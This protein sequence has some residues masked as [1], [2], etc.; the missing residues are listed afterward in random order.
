MS[1]IVKNVPEIKKGVLRSHVVE[2]PS[3]IRDCSGIKDIWKE[4][5][6]NIIYVQMLQL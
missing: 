2:V 3:V 5:K 6:I 1:K 4:N